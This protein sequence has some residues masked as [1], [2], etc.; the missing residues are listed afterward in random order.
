MLPL[1]QALVRSLDGDGDE[2]LLFTDLS[3]AF[4]SGFNEDYQRLVIDRPT[5]YDRAQRVEQIF[6]SSTQKAIGEVLRILFYI[7]RK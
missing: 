4:L 2:R 5:F 3:R 6:S 7:E 1:I